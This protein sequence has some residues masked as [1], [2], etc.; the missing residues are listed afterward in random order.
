MSGKIKWGEAA[1]AA[2]TGYFGG[3]VLEGSG[4]APMLYYEYPQTRPYL[5]TYAQGS[6]YGDSLNKDLGMVAGAKVVYDVVKHHKL[7]SEDTNLLIPYII[8]TVF[9]KNK[10]DGTSDKGVW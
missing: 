1:L 6:T 8:G 5:F 4:L 7:S 2:L 10:S 9:D 3:D